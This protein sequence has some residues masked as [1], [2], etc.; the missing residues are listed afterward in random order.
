[1]EWALALVLLGLHKTTSQAWSRFCHNVQYTLIADGMS[2]RFLVK[3]HRPWHM[4]F[5]RPRMDK[6]LARLEEASI[7]KH[8]L[9]GFHLQAPG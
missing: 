1:M 8:V 4:G 5:A 9:L 7:G 6:E 2:K 3:L